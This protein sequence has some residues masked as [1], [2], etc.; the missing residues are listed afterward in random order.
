MN[1]FA[2]GYLNVSRL[3][4]IEFRSK[5]QRMGVWND[6][7]S[8]TMTMLILQDIV[9]QWPRYAYFVWKTQ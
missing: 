3:N 4:D 7:Q 6:H 5:E 9:G 2:R 1:H 8:Q